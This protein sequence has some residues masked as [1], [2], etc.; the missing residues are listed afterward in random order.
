MESEWLMSVF[1]EYIL[2]RQI[3]APFQIIWFTLF[4]VF[5]F[6]RDSK[7]Y[8][9]NYCCELRL[10]EDTVL[11]FWKFLFY[12]IHVCPLRLHLQ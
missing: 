10:D 6:L 9:L 5:L 1:S 2:L 8:Y 3:E 4:T 11:C 7:V 12:F